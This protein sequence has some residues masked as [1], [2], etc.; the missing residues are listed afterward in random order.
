M[1]RKLVQFSESGSKVASATAEESGQRTVTRKVPPTGRG[2]NLWP[3]IDICLHVVSANTPQYES[4][5]IIIVYTQRYR[6]AKFYRLKAQG[7]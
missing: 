5:R 4:M 7:I 1:F 2:H 3:T 6:V